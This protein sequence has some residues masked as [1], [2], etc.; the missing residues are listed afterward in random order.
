M[1][2][3]TLIILFLVVAW[4][5]LA[6]RPVIPA[7][8]QGYMF[9]PPPSQDSVI[10]EHCMYGQSVRPDFIGNAFRSPHGTIVYG[11]AVSVEKL[12]LFPYLWVYLLQERRVDSTTLCYA[13]DTVATELF[14]FIEQPPISYADFSFIQTYRNRDTV[15][16]PFYEFYFVDPVQIPANVRFYVG[17]SHSWN[18]VYNHCKK[19]T[20]YCPNTSYSGYSWWSCLHGRPSQDTSCHSDGL[21]STWNIWK[22]LRPGLVDWACERCTDPPLLFG[23]EMGISG[24]KYQSRGFFPIMRPPED[25]TR[26]IPP[27]I[28]P[29]RAHAVEGFRLTGLDSA[30]ASFAWD[31]I[32]PSDWGQVGVN[33]NAYQ[34]NYAPYGQEYDEADTVIVTADS[35]TVFSRFDSTVMYKARCRA[36]S[37]HRCDIHDTMVWGDWSHEVYFHT[38]VGVPDTAPLV[39]QRVGG[40][41]YE[42]LLNGCPKF[43]WERCE[44]QDRFEVQYAE[45]GGDGW[46][47]ATITSATEYLLRAEIDS[48]ARYR[49]RV[50]AQCNHR[51]HIHDTLML[52]EWSDTVEFCL[53]PQGIG[54]AAATG[55]GLFSLAPN[56]AR[57]T[58]TVKPA[59]AAGDYPAVLTVSDTKGREVMRYS[60]TDGSPLT[61]DVSALPSG[62]YL[63]TL[64]TRSR[65][66]GTQR[67]MVEP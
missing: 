42:G 45:V 38:G 66:T 5:V 60:L 33:V 37:K 44:G 27:H 43:A 61:I 11:V 31:S 54:G 48:T 26:I 36:R 49:V 24:N 63:V 15:T 29:L 51:C 10:I 21:D 59:L 20:P 9:T 30:H 2:R 22:Y 56:P 23:A 65:R 53:H 17:I 3:I 57:G 50:R 12:E 41:R 6:Q 52:G 25:S 35:C 13:I 55:G 64:T 39:C 58:V 19:N 47:R 34:V 16:L 46:H 14:C 67:L 32:P 28:H 1:K 7:G 62:A 18:N 8:S 40:L 4:Q